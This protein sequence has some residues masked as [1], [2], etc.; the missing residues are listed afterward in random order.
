MVS[1][2]EPLILAVDGGQS[3]TLALIGNQSGRIIGVGW[4]GPSN[5]IHEPGGLERLHNAL[6]DSIGEALRKAGADAA[7][8]IHACLGMTGG[9]QQ[10]IP[11]VQS[12]A[13]NSVIQCIRTW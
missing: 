10:S 6:H 7:N 5:H 3:S 11:I 2:Q 13:P 12:I 4:G 9:A 1:A 8:I